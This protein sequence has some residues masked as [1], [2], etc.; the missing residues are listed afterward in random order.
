MVPFQT[1]WLITRC[2][3]AGVWWLESDCVGQK[4]LET[5]IFEVIAVFWGGWNPYLLRFLAMSYAMG[6][7]WMSSVCVFF[8]YAGC[9]VQFLSQ[10]FSSILR[11]GFAMVCWRCVSVKRCCQCTIAWA[12]PQD[13]QEYIV[14]W[15]HVHVLG[16]LGH[17]LVTYC[18]NVCVRINTWNW[19]VATE[20]KQCWHFWNFSI[21][22]CWV[23]RGGFAPFLLGCFGAVG[24]GGWVGSVLTFVC[25]CFRCWCYAKDVFW[26]GVGVG[27]GGWGR[28]NVRAHLLSMLMLREGRLRGWGWGWG[29]GGGV[30]C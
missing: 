24:Q 13:M 10:V 9:A 1:I 26:V 29:W 15:L 11:Y 18:R 4:K 19:P 27:V 8:V 22:S 25:T 16:K 12:V 23:D 20:G 7:F 28:V 2:C 17:L 21:P 6:S 30:L 3:V 14:W 5:I